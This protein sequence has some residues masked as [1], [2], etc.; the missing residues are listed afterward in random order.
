MYELAWDI[1]RRQSPFITMSNPWPEPP[2]YYDTP[3]K[4]YKVMLQTPGFPVIYPEPSVSQ[5]GE[6]ISMS[7]GILLR[8][9]LNQPPLGC[10]FQH[11]AGSLVIRR[12][13]GRSRLC[14]GLLEGCVE[15]AHMDIG[16]HASKSCRHNRT[17]SGVHWQKPASIFGTLFMG[18]FGLLHMMQ[19]SACESASEAKWH[20]RTCGT[21]YTWRPA[22]RLFS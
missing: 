1:A 9:F 18:Q 4:S 6:H 2:D 20:E 15:N 19:D 7:S 11:E 17:G 8:L 13:D 12:W 21:C 3:S 22:L 14:S 16:H 10:S 5:V